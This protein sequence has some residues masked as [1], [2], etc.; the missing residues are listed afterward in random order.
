[1]PR[2]VK[3]EG[4][5]QILSDQDIADAVNAT[6]DA[7]TVTTVEKNQINQVPN[8]YDASNPAQYQT[9]AQVQALLDQA[10]GEEIVEHGG[11]YQADG[12]V[13]YPGD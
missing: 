12:S 1:M 10:L 6:P 2:N 11:V 8:K 4:Q 3:Y 13:I 5:P 9:Q 7:R